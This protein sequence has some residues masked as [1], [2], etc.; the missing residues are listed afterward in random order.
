LLSGLL[1]GSSP[2]ITKPFLF[3][4]VLLFL[5]F[6]Y[7]NFFKPKA[8][9]DITDAEKLTGKLREL[10]VTASIYDYLPKTAEYA[11]TAPAPNTLI[12]PDGEVEIFDYERGTDWYTGEL[13]VVSNQATVAIPV[14]DFTGWNI[15]VN[16]EKVIYDRYSDL[17]LPV[18]ELPQGAY[19]IEAQL[20]KTNL[21]KISDYI[22]I[23]AIGVITF[24]FVKK[25]SLQRMV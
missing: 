7:G 17:G 23:F 12:V 2:K 3:T 4:A 13:S 22:S 19:V 10:Q 18:L 21:Q 6:V 9:L 15:K 5:L 1:I 8:W 14:Y 11:P 24:L 16:G 20:A 25:D